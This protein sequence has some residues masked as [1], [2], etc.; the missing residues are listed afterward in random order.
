MVI[1]LIFIGDPNEVDD[2]CFSFGSGHF[3]PKTGQDL[4]GWY[5]RFPGTTYRDARQMMIRRF[6]IKWSHQYTSAQITDAI[7]RY[8]WQELPESDWPEAKP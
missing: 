5:V 8:G 6:G 4:F 1:E 3:N 2:W 7:E